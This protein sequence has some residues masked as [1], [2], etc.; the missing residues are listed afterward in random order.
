MPDPADHEGPPPSRRALTAEDFLDAAA[1]RF[2]IGRVV[3]MR[4]IRGNNVTALMLD[5][6][7]DAP[8]SGVWYSK[9]IHFFDLSLGRRPAGARGCFPEAF[10]DLRSLGRLFFLPAGH[11]YHGEG[12]LGRQQS[13]S[14]FLRTRPED[15]EDGPF[16]RALAPVLANCLRLE[17][18]RLHKLLGR[19]TRE[20]S[21]P[22]IASDLLL[23]GLSITLL[24]ETAQLLHAM[25][26]GAVHKGG[27]SL[28]RLR[29]IEERVRGGDRSVSIAELAG[30]CHLSPRQLIRAFRAETGETIGAF[31][32]RLTIDRAKTML[33]AGDEPIAQ[34]AAKLGFASTAAFSTAFHRATGQ[35]P[36]A[37]RT[38][39]QI[40]GGAPEV[41]GRI[42]V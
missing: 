4:S 11:R 19:I 27:L 23:E 9:R 24:A 16:G 10:T 21:A 6:D 37:Y 13:L 22:S 26:D 33:G 14:L 35:Y 25:R 28:Q 32:Q 15:D 12:G 8:V 3:D 36:R 29:M 42:V 2:P 41:T 38:A 5:Y 18:D 7:R 39:R 17:N 40:G 20:L 1:E 31:I 34:V 30:L